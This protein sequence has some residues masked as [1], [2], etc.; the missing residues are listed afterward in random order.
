MIIHRTPTAL[1]VAALTLCTMHDVSAQE[2]TNSYPVVK[3]GCEY[4]YQPF[5]IVDKNGNAGGFSAELL[6]AALH[7]MHRD[8]KYRTG[9]W[10]EIRQA[11]KKGEIEALPLVARTVERE[12]E[13]D[14]TFPYLSFR[15]AL[16]VRDGTTD[17]NGTGDLKGKDVGVSKGDNAEEFLR[18]NNFGCRIHTTATFT[19]ALRALSSGKYDA[20]VIQH[21]LA[22]NIIQDAGLNNLRIVEKPIDE[23]QQDF[24]FAVKDGDKEMLS[25]LNEG[26]ALVMADGTF[27]R[28]QAKWFTGLN[29][30]SG[31]KIVIAVE[32][33]VPPF[34]FID[35][36][37]VTG[38]NV[39]LT[40]AVAEA[41]G[42]DVEIVYQP[43][44][45]VRQRLQSGAI[46][47]ACGMVYSE[48]RDSIMDFSPPF[49]VISYTAFRRT[50]KPNIRTIDD[51]HGKKLICLR[52][53]FI[54]D[55]IIK[56]HLTDSFTAVENQSAVLRMLNSGNYDYILAS[57]LPGLFWIK[58]LNLKNIQ[59]TG[60]ALITSNYC[61]A[62]N[63][64]NTELLAKLNE[65]LAIVKQTG[66]YKQIYDRRLGVLE[67]RKNYAS[68]FKDAATVLVP[69]LIILICTL[70]WSWMLK[71]QVARRTAQLK[72]EILQHKK[73]EEELRQS[74]LKWKTLFTTYPVGV[75][76][77]DKQGNII[78]SNPALSEIL[79]LDDTGLRNG[80][81][82]NRKYYKP[83]GTE[84]RHDEFPSV[85]ATKEQRIIKD[86][87]IEVRINDKSIWVKASAAPINIPG[88]ACVV[89]TNN[90]T[91]NKK[92]EE[93]L[94]K[95]S[96][97]LSLATSAARIG[98]WD[99]NLINNSIAWNERMY[100][101][102]GVSRDNFSLTVDAWINLIH[103]E[104]RQRTIIERNQVFS[105]EKEFHTAFRII[106]TNGTLSNIRAD[107]VA[108]IDQNGK[109]IRMTGINRDVT[110]NIK[111]EEMLQKTQKLESIGVL[112]GGIAHDFNN[113]LAG[114]YGFLDLAL[115][116]SNPNKIS[117]CL[118][119]ALGTIDKA[120]G[121]TQQL[122]TFAKGGA[123]IKKIDRLVP[124]IQDTTH[125]ALSGSKV[126]CEFNIEN[127]LWMCEFDK[128][129]IG[130][131]IDNLVI[132]AKQAMP[133]GG[134]IIIS[135]IN[136]VVNKN[137]AMLT[138]G[139]YV[140]ISVNDNGPGIPEEIQPR[141]F[142]PFFTTK[143]G[144]HG[145]GLSTCYSIINRHGGC[146]DVESQTGKG[147]TFH[148]YLPASPESDTVVT[149]VSPAVHEGNGTII[150]MDDE[151]MVLEVIK[152]M[153]TS[154]GYSVI[155]MRDGREVIEYLKSSND[156][157]IKKVVGIIFDLTI[158]GGIG[159]KEAIGEVLKIN[160]GI[161]VFV[162]SG[163][164]DDPVMADPVKYGFK[165][166]ICKPY[167]KM[168]LAEILSRNIG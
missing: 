63:E 28:L 128:N 116:H 113:L 168:E 58:R 97:R 151:E 60:P 91:D 136:V 161:P 164:D 10:T 129:R 79:D 165:A 101:I 74:D 92:A 144:G 162:S 9:F 121:L 130:Q 66:Q 20:V 36:G 23:L 86:V 114:I 112:A 89:S 111:T 109:V 87:E 159:G 160:S 6:A 145:L 131:V 39:E 77:V 68:I 2:T 84:M 25:I 133:D 45:I 49:A 141:I 52:G 90:I 153:L 22:V 125:F 71:R 32:E 167:I 150:L 57:K 99:W 142:D 7:A 127:G 1:L 55:Y 56:N 93:E 163:Y 137:N 82:K 158:P 40:R 37:K 140:K 44:N 46:D 12:K 29:R 76:L 18:R 122:L 16:V 54:N 43:W 143:P 146:I 65:G 33:A 88:I 123:P 53:S 73:T 83:D 8:V 47:A 50:G 81:Y 70:I 24:C 41:S 124:F 156:N 80:D 147:S 62:V 14:F 148:F 95:I 17:I 98:I 78:E 149:K 138:E 108:I 107:A 3:S 35:K 139:K 102:Y 157:E 115:A 15:G 67:P 152:I 51:L 119:K 94:T 120:R 64:G 135:A 42:F 85:R 21:L 117:E 4:G 5:C 132:N 118:K 48:D 154:F 126:S 110:E 166:S 134:R 30:L 96:E 38:F 106:H 104:D 72:E 103:P 26:L 27:H 100:E 19:D 61:Y 31:K 69:L 59:P 13:F 75:S 105:R 155:C 11:L 34:S